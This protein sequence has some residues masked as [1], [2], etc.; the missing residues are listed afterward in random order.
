MKKELKAALEAVLAEQV[1]AKLG[2]RYSR[3]KRLPKGE[4]FL[5]IPGELVYAD[6]SQPTLG[7]FV[8][9]IP[10]QKRHAFTV[11]LGWSVDGQ[12]PAVS[13]RPSIRLEE[14]VSAAPSRGF[15]RLSEFYSRLGEDWDV[16]PMNVLDPASFTRFMEFEMRKPDPQE[17][18]TLVRPLV[19]DALHK[20][21][22]HLPGFFDSLEGRVLP[23]E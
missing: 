5:V 3:L 6:T 4:G 14:A 10:D 23:V 18:R 22:K 1:P 9:F 16:V 17:A 21:Q 20:L 12:F 7:R 11:E 13:M 15:V 8:S 2:E 19:E